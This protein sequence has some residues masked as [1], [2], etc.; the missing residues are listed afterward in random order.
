MRPTS[1]PR[2]SWC[3]RLG[4]ADQLFLRLGQSRIVLYAPNLPVPRLGRTVSSPLFALPLALSKRRLSKRLRPT[5]LLLHAHLL[6]PPPAVVFPPSSTCRRYRAF[7]PHRK[8]RLPPPNFPLLPRR[9]GRLP[10]TFAPTRHR[11]LLVG[12]RLTITPATHRPAPAA[13]SFSPLHRLPPPRTSTH[14]RY[15]TSPTRR[16]VRRRR[17]TASLRRER[18]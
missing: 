16:Q 15:P 5:I 6:P 3:D 11:K 7:P 17:G 14:T 4:I 12:R 13:T 18:H 9:K 10:R 2:R 8:I 1:L